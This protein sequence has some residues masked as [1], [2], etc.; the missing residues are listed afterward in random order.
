MHHKTAAMQRGRMFWRRNRSDDPK[1]GTSE[2]DSR[3]VLQPVRI[4]TTDSTIAGWIDIAGQR[5]SDVLN[6]EDLLSVS[7]SDRPDESDWFVI[8][9]DAMLIAVPP[10]H[11]SD[12]IMRVHRVKR[13]ISVLTGHY[14]VR[15]VVHLVAGIG[16]DPFLARSTQHFLPLTEAWVT[17]TK[18]PEVDEQHPTVLLNV[19]STAQR[20]Q[21]E[22]LE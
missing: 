9:R 10:A 5:L 12:R 16:L 11:R 14:V 7:R 18:R 6:V 2:H 21:L 15:G 4:F 13:R 1:R 22:V 19:R 17:S 3:A 20:L 8:E